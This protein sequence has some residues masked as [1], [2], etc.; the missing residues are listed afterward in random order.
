M[1]EKMTLELRTLLAGVVLSRAFVRKGFV[2]L[3]MKPFFPK[4]VHTYFGGGY[5]KTGKGES[6][7]ERVRLYGQN[8]KEFLECLEPYFLGPQ[9]VRI[10]KLLQKWGS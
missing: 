3:N 8:A 7:R 10:R 1:R 9:G 6:C 5:R 2:E 4:L